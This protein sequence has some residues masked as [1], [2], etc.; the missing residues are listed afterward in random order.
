MMVPEPEK[1]ATIPL[2]VPHLSGEEWPF[3]KECLDTNWVSYLGPF[4]ERFERELAECVGAKHAVAT[5][6]GTAALHLALI[7]AGVGADDEVLMPALTFVAPANAVR[8]CNAVPWCTDI[9]TSDWQWD[10][11][12]LRDILAK[13]SVRRDGK[14]INVRT[15]RRIAALLPVHLLGGMCDIDAVAEL[16]S[17]YGLPLIEDAA[18]CLGASY[19]ERYIGAPIPRVSGLVRIIVTSFNG[20]KIIT[21]GGGGALLTD[22]AA[23]ASK[24]KH[25]STTAKVGGIEFFHDE[26][27]FNYRLTN[28]A[29]ALGV[30]QLG[31]LEEFVDIKR[32]I[33][34]RYTAAFTGVEGLRTHP[35]M[36][37]G[38][39]TFW[40][41]SLILNRESRS[42]VEALIAAGITCRPPWVPLHM[43]PSF[44]GCD[45]GHDLSVAKN[46]FECGLSLPCSVGLTEQEQERVISCVQQAL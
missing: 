19:R 29:A 45:G 44:G 27:G 21:T 5:S 33:A 12:K 36:R 14:V 39:G 43:L 7:L 1:V 41:Y 34:A 37:H 24:A 31:K 2:C 26:V 32:A 3:V 40:M 13:E 22:D 25:L 23:L 6:S 11:E 15:G 42:V 18:E 9:C 46:F 28:I 4:V 17:E 30:A 8:Y 16:A 35:D 20:N 38:R 10:V